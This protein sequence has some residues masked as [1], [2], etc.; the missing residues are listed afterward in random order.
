MNHR[1]RS[2]TV[3][4]RMQQLRR[5][6]DEDVEDVSASARTMVDWKHY[7][8]THPLGVFRG[9]GRLGF[10]N[11]SKRPKRHLPTAS[12]RDRVDEDRSVGRQTRADGPRTD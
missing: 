9:G 4:E 7:V 3:R 10:L 12:H 5:E 8:K 1:P 6:I 2:D 11:R